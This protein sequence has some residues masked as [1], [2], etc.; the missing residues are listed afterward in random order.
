M[1]VQ[2]ELDASITRVRK[3]QELPLGLPARGAMLRGMSEKDDK[4][5]HSQG[6]CVLCHLLEKQQ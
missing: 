2:L 3:L 1:K 5:S 4:T 6:A